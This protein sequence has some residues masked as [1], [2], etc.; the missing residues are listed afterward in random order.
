LRT[1]AGEAE[2]QEFNRR[3]LQRLRF[4]KNPRNDT[5]VELALFIENDGQIYR[6]QTLPIIKNLQRKIA[7]GTYN[8]T[9]ALKLWRHLADRGA[10]DY[11]KQHGSP[12]TTTWFQMFSTK[13]RDDTAKLLA[14]KYEEHV[15]EPLP[16][17]A[18]RLRFR[19]VR[20]K[21]PRAVRFHVIVAPYSLATNRV[22]MPTVPETV[23]SKHSSLTA[24]RNKLGSL[25]SG[26]RKGV[27]SAIVPRGD[28]Y[29]LF[30]R[31]IQTG[32]EISRTGRT[33]NRNPVGKFYIGGHARG[34]TWYYR[35][36]TQSFTDS[37]EKGTAYRSRAH[38]ESIAKSL[39]R[40]LP[41]SI[42]K[43]T[44]TS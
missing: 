5:A 27:I 38:A 2:R 15:R 23:I 29:R 22:G 3:T 35:H 21:N 6:S 32:Q 9:L 43:I 17:K 37:K 44:V 25:I 16:T 1:P 41:T 34:R 8:P 12:H 11:F 10:H 42:E 18:K 33:V 26:K 4:N 31:D 40:R 7:K 36:S 30:V 20:R 13:D 19:I 24:A 39:V 28:G 14:E